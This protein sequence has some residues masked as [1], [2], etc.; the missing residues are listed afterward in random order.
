MRAILSA[1]VLLA[2][3]APALAADAPPS[4]SDRLTAAATENRLTI[5][6]DGGRFSGP[7]WERLLAEGRAAQFLMLGE[8]HGIAENPKLAAA[9]FAALEPAGYSKLAI[10]VSPPM[11]EALDSA[12]RRGV[13]GLTEMFSVPG[14]TP[15]FFGM[16]E[17]AAMLAS[18][19]ASVRGEGSALWGVDYEVGGDRLLIAMLE[20]KKKPQAAASALAA[21][22]AASTAAWARYDETRDPRFIFSFS[23]D[24]ALARAV[25]DAWPKRD[26]ESA[27]ILDT[28]EETL[29]INRLWITRE[30][31]LSN[32][33]RGAFMRA[34]F[35][36]HWRT[37][38]AAGRTPRV[39]LKLGASHLVRGRSNSEIFDLGTLLPEL[40][41]VDGQST[42]SVLV[43][44]GDGSAVAQFDPSA[45]RYVP[46]PAD[47]GYRHGLQPLLAAASP[48]AFSLIDLRPLRKILSRQGDADP[49]LMRVVHGFDALL[50]LSGSTPSSNLAASR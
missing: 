2:G 24:P 1:A 18:V 44:S 28:L 43:L 16:A 8:D 23:G 37:E 49:E 15:A 25:R 36:A 31:Y 21:L 34:N 4:V 14:S 29:E 7:G 9:L 10:E 40:A 26:A 39:M 46:R 27:A 13:E 32:V 3:A 50:V 5:D 6:F 19:R 12:A 30:G 17:E 45:W 35:L 47:D 33:R 38:Q 22:R 41:A 20:K 48:K 11:A 42:F